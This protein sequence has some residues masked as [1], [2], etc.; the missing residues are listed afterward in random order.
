MATEAIDNI[1]EV[2]F[3]KWL[4]NMPQLTPHDMYKKLSRF[5]YVGQTRPR[6]AICLMAYRHIKKIYRL[7][8]ENI[9]RSELPPKENVLLMGPTG[10]GKTYL[11]EILFGKILDIPNVVVDTTALTET[12][13]VGAD[14]SS[15][16]TRLIRSTMDNPWR[17]YVG[18]V[19]LDEFD[20]LAT[21]GNSA[22]F[23]GAGST[24]D[25]SGAG[26]QKELLKIVEGTD[27]SV[28]LAYSDSR[29]AERVDMHTRDISFIGC[30]AFSGFKKS[31]QNSY[32]G[33]GMGFNDAEWVES[34]SSYASSV[35][36]GDANKTDNLVVYGFMPE[37]IGRF[38]RIVTFD[39]LEKSDLVGILRRNTISQYKKELEIE[40]IELKIDSSVYGIAAQACIERGTGARALRN[41]FSETL[42]DACFEAFSCKKKKK[43][44]TLSVRSGEIKCRL[45]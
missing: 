32:S 41:Y 10:C 40:G 30:G 18:V 20:K 29:T 38:S 12:G 37:L 2:E 5:G 44:I 9:K 34:V 14:S 26:V 35:S 36:T 33:R 4:K 22:S 42:E 21:C 43:A 19:C 39:V 17:A 28:P 7:Y 25:V 45:E 16:L 31:L 1:D 8:V 24:K 13:Y 15:V 23:S 6:K 3:R 27:I 11:I